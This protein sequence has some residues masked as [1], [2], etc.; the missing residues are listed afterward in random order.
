[1]VVEHCP[2]IL[3][4][5]IAHSVFPNPRFVCSTTQHL[6]TL[7]KLGASQNWREMWDRA[8]RALR[9][10]VS[11]GRK[12]GDSGQLVFERHCR[13]RVVGD[14]LKA[15]RVCESHRLWHFRPLEPLRLGVH[16]WAPIDSL[17]LVFSRRGDASVWATECLPGRERKTTE[18]FKV[19]K[20]KVGEIVFVALAAKAASSE[21]G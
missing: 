17:L 21:G 15:Q 7:R 10:E 8:R 12:D 20:A 18:L 14:D 3:H 1:M 9:S 2:S 19:G 4:V 13:P 6:L 16:S 11:I 5:G